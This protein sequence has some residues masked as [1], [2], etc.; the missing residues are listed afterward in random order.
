[1]CM[2][3]W[4]IIRGFF[5]VLFLVITI[6]TVTTSAE[7]SE[8]ELKGPGQLYAT[9]AVLLDADSGRVLYGKNA[10]EPM[11]MASTTKIMTCILVL[12]NGS[13]EDT[14]SVSAYAAT[15]PK[16][17]LSVRKGE[18]YLVKDLLYSLMLESHNDSA[19][20]LAEYIGKQYLSKDLAGKETSDYTTEESRQAV[21]AFAR[22]MNQKAE[23]IGC[24]DTWFIT[25]NGLDA[26]EESR[27][28]HTT[29]TEL[30]MIMSYCIKG[31]PQ[32][33]C[34]LEI[35]R[36]SCHSFYAN[37]RSFTCNNHN[38]FLTMM[39]GALSGKT[40]FTNKA[41]YCYVGALESEGRTFVVALLACGWPS[42]K[43]YK[44]SDARELMKYG[45]EHYFYRNLTEGAEGTVAE[46]LADILVKE[47]QSSVLGSPVYALTAKAEAARGL[48]RM[49][50][51]EEEKVRVQLK[52]VKELEAPV[53]AGTIVGYVTYSVQDVI[54]RVEEIVVTNTVER[55]TPGWCLEQVFRRFLLKNV[56]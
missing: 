34:F 49:L 16:V 10:E 6:G 53:E 42:H 45:Q 19:V 44:W 22:L 8:G 13:M 12:E 24:R 35:T 26:S 50:L 1:M 41:G 29:A 55:I 14:V 17:K 4:K 28:H 27:G 37:A 43:S 3:G 11:A 25:P 21:A 20:V 38:A 15:S 48:E 47:G 56:S 5:G 31:S 36:T 23:E 9:S 33:E 2:K 52:K 51:R 7:E 40:G 39:E 30:A 32:R 46:Q 54:Y 18:H